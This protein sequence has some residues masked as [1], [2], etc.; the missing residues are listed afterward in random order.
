MNTDNYRIDG[1]VISTQIH[2]GAPYATGRPSASW[3]AFADG[4]RGIYETGVTEAEA[5]GKLVISL[6]VLE[7]HD[8]PLRRGAMGDAMRSLD[9]EDAK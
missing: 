4:N 7:R 6:A 9:A 5:I 1:V 8:T 2:P 3:M